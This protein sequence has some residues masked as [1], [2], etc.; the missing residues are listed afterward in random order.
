MT[1]QT[2]S[3]NGFR[4]RV[5]AALSLLRAIL[6]EIFDESAYARFL[7]RTRVASSPHAYESFL[8][9]QEAAKSRRPK[10]C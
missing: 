9:E 5:L 3:L 7:A 1:T 8:R 6:L 2:I 10:C 4:G